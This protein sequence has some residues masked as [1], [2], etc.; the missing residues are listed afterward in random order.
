MEN[1]QDNEKDNDKDYYDTLVLSSGGVYGIAHLG[2][3]EYL[4]EHHVLDKVMHFGGCSAGA[5]ICYY[6]ILGYSPL[7]MFLDVYNTK[8][9]PE[10]LHELTK[11]AL[12]NLQSNGSILNNNL[13]IDHVAKI[14]KEKTGGR[15]LTFRQLYIL[16]SKTFTVVAVNEDLKK[17]IYFNHINT[18]DVYVHLAVSASCA[19]PLIFNP[20]VINDQ[21]YCDGVCMDPLPV[22][23]MDNGKRKILAI[24]LEKYETAGTKTT[25]I[26]SRA[27]K[28]F[29]IMTRGICANV[30]PNLSDQC[31]VKHLCIDIALDNW[32]PNIKIGADIFIKG[33]NFLST[34][35]FEKKVLT[36][37]DAPFSFPDQDDDESGWMG[38]VAGSSSGI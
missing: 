8:I 12:T 1:T 24:L 13:F 19:I 38:G 26:F 3:L 23:Y 31:V 30:I 18:P 17:P 37:N 10:N 34:P 33:L 15:L 32:I 11:Q 21:E 20:V 27:S 2:V 16:T 22:Q 29:S 4:R 5:L 36:L 25:S 14:T 7:R 28:Y 9:F 35:Y 6:H